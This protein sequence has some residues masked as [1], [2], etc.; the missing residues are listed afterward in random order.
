MDKRNGHSTDSNRRY[1]FLADCVSEAY[2]FKCS[3]INILADKAQDT[4]QAGVSATRYWNHIR[5]HTG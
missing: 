5:Q 2:D 1:L 3:W 4:V